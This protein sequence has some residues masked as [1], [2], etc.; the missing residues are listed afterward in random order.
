MRKVLGVFGAALLL[1]CG[2]LALA[3]NH[4]PKAP[5]PKPMPAP[6]PAAPASN[7]AA[8]SAAQAAADAKA[9]AAARADQH[10]DQV[11]TQTQTSQSNSHNANDSNASIDVQYKDRLQA[12][13]IGAP[14]VYASGSCAS[15]WSAGLAVPGGGISGGRAKA[16]ASC[17]RRELIRVL[18][19]LNPWLALKIACEDP[20]IVEMRLRNLASASDCVYAPPALP[21]AAKI[22]EPPKESVVVTRDELRETVDRAFKQTSKK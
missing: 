21:P 4:P 9:A 19:P 5:P 8:T 3:T 7:S 2:P 10:Q 1:A 14:P 15:G 13:S 11:Q 17:D 6:Q 16:D 12:P 20:L 22:P 18:T